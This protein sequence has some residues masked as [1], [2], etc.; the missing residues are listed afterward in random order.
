[1]VISDQAS[2]QVPF[3]PSLKSL[4]SLKGI[5]I[6]MLGHWH[7]LRYQIQSRELQRSISWQ[8]DS[9]GRVCQHGS[10]PQHRGSWSNN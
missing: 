4:R 8:M 2:L 10:L 5:H 3:Y 7:R 9:T 6:G 1:M